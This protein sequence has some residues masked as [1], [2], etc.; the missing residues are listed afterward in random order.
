MKKKGKELPHEKG[1]TLETYPLHVTILL[2]TQ[3]VEQQRNR[4]IL[5]GSKTSKTLTTLTCLLST[6]GSSKIPV[7]KRWLLEMTSLTM[8]LR[9][10]RI[11]P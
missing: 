7:S 3:I 10:L 6:L 11:T 4:I 1:W 2:N 8:L 5:I 9:F